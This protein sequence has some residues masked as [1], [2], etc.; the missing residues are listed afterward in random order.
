MLAEDFL[1]CSTGPCVALEHREGRFICG[2]VRN[3]LAYLYQAAHP[4]QEVPVHEEATDSVASRD[5]SATIASA[6]GVGLGCD[7][8]DDQDDARMS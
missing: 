6:L 4:D 8:S 2:L 5:L 3:P 1:N 7:A